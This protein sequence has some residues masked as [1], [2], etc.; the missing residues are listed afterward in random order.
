MWLIITIV[1]EIILSADQEA[2]LTMYAL[3]RC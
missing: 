2:K 3:V 1:L